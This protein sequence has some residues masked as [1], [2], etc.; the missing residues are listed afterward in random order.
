M[1]VINILDEKNRLFDIRYYCEDSKQMNSH[2]ISYLESR[3]LYQECDEVMG[4]DRLFQ[5][6]D[7]CIA[8]KETLESHLTRG[9]VPPKVQE[10][11]LIALEQR[12]TYEVYLDKHGLDWLDIIGDE[13]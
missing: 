9:F 1:K 10:D 12:H 13:E 4:L 8:A 3:K 6:Y 7:D 5:A 11:Y 2:G